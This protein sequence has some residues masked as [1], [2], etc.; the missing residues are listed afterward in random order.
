MQLRQGLDLLAEREVEAKTRG[1]RSGEN[2]AAWR[3]NLKN[4]FPAK[5][6]LVRGHF[7]SMDHE[8]IPAFMAWFADGGRY[9]RAG[10]GVDHLD[11]SA[12]ERRH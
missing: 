4:V 6:K 7:K 3:D 5:P 2:P 8:E 1:H 11:R 9:E 10:P 12:P